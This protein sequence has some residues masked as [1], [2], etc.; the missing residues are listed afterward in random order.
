MVAG[1]QYNGRWLMETEVG[2]AD[3]EERVLE[4]LKSHDGKFILTPNS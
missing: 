3:L 4:I 2:E 1:A